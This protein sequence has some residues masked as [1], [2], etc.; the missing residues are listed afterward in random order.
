MPDLHQEIVS[1]GF[2]HGQE[3]RAVFGNRRFADLDLRSR[4]SGPLHLNRIGNQVVGGNMQPTALGR[5]KRDRTLA[6]ACQ[7]P[8]RQTGV[9]AAEVP[10]RGINGG[11]G[12][13]SDRPDRRGVSDIE[14]VAPETFDFFGLP[15][16]QIRSKGFLQQ[17]YDRRSAG[18]DRVTVARSRLA[19][20]VRDP[21]DRGFLADE[22]L[23][24]VGALHL[25]RQVDQEDFDGC[26]PGH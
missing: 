18:S 12:Q 15:T 1:H 9:A 14:Q 20:L 7:P 4:K 23:D 26:D 13:G 21:D 22:G 17:T 8:K 5:I 11:H 2:P 16:N 19:I 25:R 24:G 3:A 6:A 10:K